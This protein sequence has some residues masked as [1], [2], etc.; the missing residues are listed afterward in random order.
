M[1]FDVLGHEAGLVGDALDGGEEDAL[2][3]VVVVRDE[4]VPGVAVEEE[5]ADVGGGCN[6]GGLVVDAVEGAEHAVVGVRH[7]ARYVH[8]EVGGC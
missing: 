5:V 4:L 2:F 3:G 7:F 1:L 6:V 8:A